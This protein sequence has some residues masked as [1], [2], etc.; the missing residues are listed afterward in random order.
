MKE[1]SNESNLKRF[2]TM[3]H[4]RQ[5]SGLIVDG[6]KTPIV[7]FK[8][9]MDLVRFDKKD[10]IKPILRRKSTIVEASQKISTTVQD[11][12]RTSALVQGNNKDEV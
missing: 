1:S 4:E 8:E 6:K 9:P 10:E 3:I 5:H 7:S 12:R 2:K 11:K